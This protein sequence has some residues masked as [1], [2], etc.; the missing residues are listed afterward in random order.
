MRICLIGPTHPFRGGIAHYTTLLYRNLQKQHQVTLFSFKRQYPQW[1]FPGATD[2]DPSRKP[3]R[4]E[5]GVHFSIDSLNPVSWVRTAIAIRRCK[6]DIVIVP[7]W[8]SF[9]TVPF[10]T[11][12]RLIRRNPR[13]KILFLCHN[14][15]EHESLGFNQVCTRWV[16]GQGDCFIVHSRQEAISLK[17]K[18]PN[19]KI[20]QGFHPT[21]EELQ[22]VHYSR[23][24]ARHRLNLKGNVVL[25]FG[26][27]RPYKGLEYLLN[28]IPIVAQKLKNNLSVMVVGEC[29]Q[30]EDRYQKLIENLNIRDHILRINAYVPN[31]EVGLYFAAADLV[32]IPYVSAT[33]SGI[34]QAAFG[35]NRP[36]VA[37]EVGGLSEAVRHG[38]TGYLV[39]PADTVRLSEAMIT[40]FNQNQGPVFEREIAHE[41][42]RFS[43][44]HMVKL[45]E[46]C[47][48]EMGCPVQ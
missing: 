33:G 16:L 36:V 8:T 24:E 39:P 11:I 29:W 25:F 44:D 4:Q 43:W 14:V 20:Y 21:Y 7:W 28:A 26:F 30:D 48:E 35:A 27:I 40:F 47:G 22:V 15:Q 6:P 12:V 37:T 17:K 19:P 1:L 18:L 42:E 10:F 31:E 38:F 32:A 5:G 9:W 34:L 2:R 41:K 46:R 13:I 23:A 3:I 45:I